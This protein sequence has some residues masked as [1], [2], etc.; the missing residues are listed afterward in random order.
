MFDLLGGLL[1]CFSSS[2]SIVTVQAGLGPTSLLTWSSTAWLKV[3]VVPV[4]LSLVYLLVRLTGCGPGLPSSGVKEIDI[5]ATLEHVRDQRP[6]MVRTKVSLG[7]INFPHQNIS[8]CFAAVFVKGQ[9]VVSLGSMTP[10]FHRP[11]GPGRT[12]SPPRPRN[13]R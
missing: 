5:A 7:S 12:T 2:V 6:G 11:R 1:L 8:K 4:L 10:C 9:L 3:T 13:R